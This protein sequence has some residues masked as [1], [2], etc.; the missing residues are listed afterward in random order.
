MNFGR[1]Q[2]KSPP[3]VEKFFA[4]EPEYL[5]LIYQ[6]EIL[7]VLSPLDEGIF[8]TCEEFPEWGFLTNGKCEYFTFPDGFRKL[9]FSAVR[10]SAEHIL[11]LDKI[12]S[13]K[14]PEGYDM[15]T[16]RY[17]PVAALKKSGEDHFI[18]SFYAF[19]NQS[20]LLLE[21]WM[22]R[23]SIILSDNLV[24]IGLINLAEFP[25]EFPPDY[26]TNY[27]SFWDIKI[28]DRKH[29]KFLLDWWLIG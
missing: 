8:K 28:P 23:G 29:L 4:K 19:W 15:P 2:P 12:P 5:A 27:C 10:I 20:V 14:F 18:L 13:G 25:P 21:N 7:P 11:L 1:S 6:E 17:Y 16:M 26:T 9:S 22:T 24:V 3:E